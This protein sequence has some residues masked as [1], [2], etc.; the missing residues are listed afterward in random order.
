LISNHINGQQSFDLYSLPEERS[1]K[2][3]QVFEDLTKRRV[4]IYHQPVDHNSATHL[5][6]H[7]LGNDHFQLS[8]YLVAETPRHIRDDITIT[9]IYFDTDYIIETYS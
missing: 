2:L 6:R 5:V 1:I 3:R 7:A 8:N 9:I 4:S